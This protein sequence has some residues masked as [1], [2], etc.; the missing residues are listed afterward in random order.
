MGWLRQAPS[1]AE[2]EGERLWFKIPCRSAWKGV[3]F[4]KEAKPEGM[5]PKGLV[6]K[7]VETRNPRGGGGVGN[8]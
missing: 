1:G 4:E 3:F 2:N 5:E 7:L 6:C 8:T